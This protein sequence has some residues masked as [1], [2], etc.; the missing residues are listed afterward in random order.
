MLKLNPELKSYLWMV[1]G[2]SAG[3]FMISAVIIVPI[4]RNIE[5]SI[6]LGSNIPLFLLIVL[7]SVSLLHLL[8][9]RKI[10]WLK[11]VG[12]CVL[13]GT[14]QSMSAFIAFPFYMLLYAIGGSAMTP[15]SNLIY[16]YVLSLVAILVYSLTMFKARGFTKL[17]FVTGLVSIPIAFLFGVV[18]NSNTD[19]SIFGIF[20]STGA[21]LGLYIG[22]KEQRINLDRD[23]E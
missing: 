5:A 3:L 13:I 11:L 4:M 16:D 8:L 6:P 22:L 1:M 12:I 18:T 15:V 19:L 23:Y 10:A 14:L 20:L 9:Y 2:I 17:P 7:V 21:S